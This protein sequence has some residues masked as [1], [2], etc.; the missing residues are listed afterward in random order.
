[1]AAA[2]IQA[3]VF[4][5]DGMIFDT[6][7]LMVRTYNHS[8]TTHGYPAL[9]E[10]KIFTAV[11]KQV[12]ESYRHLVPGIDADLVVETHRAF[13]DKNLHLIAPYEGLEPM[14]KQLKD[15]RIK[16][17]VFT[18]SG[19]NSTNDALN[20]TGVAKYFETV[21]T[22]DDVKRHK[23]HPEG[24][25]LA[26]KRLGVSPANAA[27]LGDSIYDIGAGKDA[28]VRLTIGITHGFGKLADLKKARPNYIVDSLSE[29]PPLLIGKM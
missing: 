20:V 12:H 8:L 10:S 23:P 16:M 27:M 11:G 22:A 29:I 14:L 13:Q 21:I 3:A 26:L 5:F 25:L 19:P 7:E 15:N 9:D 18:A 6:R 2:K 28:N 4:D 17:A 24:L 1:M